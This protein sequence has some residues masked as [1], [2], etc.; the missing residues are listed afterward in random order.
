MNENRMEQNHSLNHAPFLEPDSDDG[1]GDGARDGGESDLGGCHHGDWDTRKENLPSSLQGRGRLREGSPEKDASFWKRK[2]QTQTELPGNPKQKMLKKRR[3]PSQA[4]RRGE[5]GLR[6]KLEGQGGRGQGGSMETAG[7]V[8][9]MDR[10]SLQERVRRRRQAPREKSGQQVLQSVQGRGFW[11]S[12]PGPL[13]W[14]TGEVRSLPQRLAAPPGEF[15][16]W[17]E[18][19]PWKRG[20]ISICWL[21][22]EGLGSERHPAQQG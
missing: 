8:A 3:I 5:A 18:T 19:S 14:R 6:E 13:D 9:A 4:A 16:K 12:P 2:F 20:A 10:L 21:W 7:A 22:G 1:G 15:Q 17:W 11:A